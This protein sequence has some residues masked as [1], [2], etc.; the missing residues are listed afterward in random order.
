MGE[1]GERI[2]NYINKI[3]LYQWEIGERKRENSTTLRGQI[4][5]S[6]TFNFF[7]KEHLGSVWYICLKT[8]NCCLKTFVEI[9]VGEKVH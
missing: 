7:E 4:I 6:I 1:I 3:F 9:R 2:F 5:L 8:K